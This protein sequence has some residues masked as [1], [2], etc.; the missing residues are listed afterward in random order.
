MRD[1]NQTSKNQSRGLQ[2]RRLQLRGGFS[3]IELI[4]VIGI[5]AILMGFLLPALSAARRA[6]QTTQCASNIRQLVA[7][8]INYSVES[9][10]VF[11][12]ND[13][14]YNVY[15]YNSDAIG[16]YMKTSIQMSNSEQ[17]IGGVFVCPADLE[18]AV[19]SYAM[20]IFAGHSVSRFVKPNLESDQPRGKLWNASVGSSS[21]MILII[22]QFSQEDW[23][24]DDQGSSIGDGSTGSWSSKAISGWAG[25]LPGERF[26]TGG[27]LIAARFGQCASEVCYF[28]HRP[29]KQN[30]GL[31]VAMGRLNI[32]FADGHVEL[33]S[34]KDLVTIDP[35]T[36][37]ETVHSTFRA[38]W[39][40]N[41]R[42]VESAGIQ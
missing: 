8:L 2:L 26:V 31:G 1:M 41:D 29:A 33:L 28:R 40:P 12:A 7:A 30:F 6:A 9:R 24:N 32:G 35:A 17:C 10:G 23:P 11:P 39:S 5:I 22:E 18:G 38:M 20:N 37:P 34:E 16:K 27:Q 15:W 21:N 14:E 42:E 13:G 19:R 3:L 25:G 36:T 4:T